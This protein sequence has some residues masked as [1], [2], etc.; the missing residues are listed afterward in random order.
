MHHGRYVLGDGEEAP[1]PDIEAC[2]LRL[3]APTRG[4]CNGSETPVLRVLGLRDLGFA[5]RRHMHSVRGGQPGRDGARMREHVFDCIPGMP[6]RVVPSVAEL[7]A[8]RANETCVVMCG[9]NNPVSCWAGPLSHAGAPTLRLVSELFSSTCKLRVRKRFQ[10][11]S[12]FL[13]TNTFV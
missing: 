11:T 2:V 7:S 3:G 6:F 4:G 10:E 5:P 1:A 9:F 13:L 8:L 12:A